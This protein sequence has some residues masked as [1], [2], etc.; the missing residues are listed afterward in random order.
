[1]SPRDRIPI[2]FP[3]EADP[4]LV[5]WLPRPASRNVPRVAGRGERLLS[6]DDR[7]AASINGRRTALGG[8]PHSGWLP[9]GA[10]IRPPTPRSEEVV[11]FLIEGD[12]QGAML[13]WQG[14]DG[15]QADYQCESVEAAVE[16]AA[17]S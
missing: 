14:R 17:F 15:S 10:A 6:A 16:Q 8:E 3:Q 5:G 2:A 12:G 9:D 13:Y 7:D 4:S 1:M 11:D